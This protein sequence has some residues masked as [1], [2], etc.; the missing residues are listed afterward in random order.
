LAKGIREGDVVLSP[1]GTETYRAA[2]VRGEYLY[3]SGGTLPHRRSVHWLPQMIEPSDM[4]DALRRSMAYIGTVSNVSQYASEVEALVGRQVLFGTD[5]TVEDPY[6]F[7]LEE[8]LEDF[9]VA[10]WTQTALGKEYDVYE[11]DGNRVGQQYEIEK[12]RIDILAIRKDGRE[13][14]VVELKKGR[15]SDAVVGQT[16]S[17][18]GYV[19]DQL[20]EEGQV[21]KGAIIAQDDDLKIRRALMVVPNVKFYRYQVSFK[22]IDG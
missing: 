7:A 12:G 8:H 15:A 10:N 18:M 11:V 6:T 20:A 21:V 13:L 19:Q 14:L 2:E 22:L 5:D 3:V 1:T 9:L 4:S 16:L 17:Y